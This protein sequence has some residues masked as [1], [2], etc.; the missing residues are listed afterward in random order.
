M[1]PDPRQPQA[2][3]PTSYRE[4]YEAAPLQ[5]VAIIKR[6]LPERDQGRFLI[7]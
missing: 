7:V 3:G 5:R 1:S 4:L 6:G 2:L